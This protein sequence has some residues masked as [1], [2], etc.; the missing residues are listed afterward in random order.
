MAVIQG[1]VDR[2]VYSNDDNGYTVIK[3]LIEDNRGITAVGNM[4]GINPGEAIRIEG[5]WTTHKK[6]GSQFKVTSY[7][8]VF[9]KTKRGI[10]KYLES[11]IIKG[12]G[13]VLAE[14]LIKRFGENVISILDNSPEELKEVE[15]IGDKKFEVIIKAWQEQKKVRDVMI[16]LQSYGISP[17]YASK[18]YK[19]YGNSC[20]AVLKNNPYQM[21]YDIAGIGFKTADK[22]AISSG[23]DPESPERIKAAIIYQLENL[24]E[25]GHTCYPQEGLI[26]E[27]SKLLEINKPE[28]VEEALSSLLERGTLIKES[29]SDGRQPLIYL[30]SLYDAEVKI[31][32]ILKERINTKSLHSIC[33][34]ESEIENLEYSEKIKLAKEQKEAI[35]L[36][37]SNNL[38][39]ITGGPG[40]GKTT[41]LKFVTTICRKNALKVL[42]AAPTGRAAKRLSEVTGMEAKTIHRLLE[43]NPSMGCFLKNSDSPLKADIIILDESSMIDIPLFANF[44]EALPPD[45]SLL[46]VGD[47]N[48]LP[49]VGPGNL[50]RDLIESNVI[51]CVKLEKIF[52]QEANSNIVINAHRINRGDFPK[53]PKIKREE[54]GDFYFFEEEDQ[55]KVL[56]I[57]K[58]L[59][60]KKIP[61]KF[62]YNPF[63]DIQVLTPMHK[64]TVGA[65]NIN[66]VLQNILN[67]QKKELVRGNKIFRQKDKVM[68]IKNNYEKEVFN[69]DIGII[70]AID[71]EEQNL[72]VNFDDRYVEYDFGELDE[73][74]LSYAISIHK[75]QG[76]EYNA[77]IIPILT[78]HYYLLQRNLLYTAITRGKKL[79][80]LTGTRKAIWMAIKNNRVQERYTLLKE[81]ILKTE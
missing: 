34:L 73:L 71:F 58:E 3:L 53:I 7:K 20:I 4:T 61:Q 27:C 1:I 18:I 81:R 14:R 30:N 21:A 16:F 68:Q 41:I 25:D 52:R 26:E 39:I 5:E 23:F 66:S 35:K 77:V 51:A 80:V 8:W 57:I 15:G 44:L 17:A 47:V 49:S 55:D 2:I 75:S 54:K 24:L 38:S 64:G 32:A 19:R 70:E 28:L 33:N 50:L 10:Q 43:Y 40:T 72:V 13:P 9:P 60:C 59:Y 65:M 11:G 67:P 29:F 76:S 56:N 6:F 78:Q 37:F 22:I 74:T 48:Q 31:S 79:V 12:I 46:M 42:L 36:V 45:C 69:G 62:G 63:T